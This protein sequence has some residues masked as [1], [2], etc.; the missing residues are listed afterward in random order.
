MRTGPSGGR[1]GAEG[2]GVQLYAREQ[3]EAERRPARLATSVRV[4]AISSALGPVPA[5]RVR[6]GD[7]RGE[8]RPAEARPRK[9]G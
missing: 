1:V 2:G 3:R 6:G 5:R 9:A 8:V 4:M 7:A